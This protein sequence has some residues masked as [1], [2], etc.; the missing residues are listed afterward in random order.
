MSKTEE[1]IISRDC[2]A[3]AVPSGEMVTLPKGSKVNITHRLGGNFTVI[4]DYGMAR[5]DRE[6]VDALGEE[7]PTSVVQNSLKIEHQGP[8]DESAIWE[9]LKTVFD[10]E[11]PVNIVDLGLVYS[12]NI[13]EKENDN[14]NVNV[15]MTLTAP[16][17]GMGP[18]S[19]EDA[20]NKMRDVPGV[21]EVDVE[22]VWDPPWNQD[23]IS[24]EGK[25]QL[26]LI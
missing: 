17:C 13:E 6:N 12:L 4:W 5:I 8:P 19:A 11:I 2:Q 18:V 20:K 22:L 15:T 10:P 3:T 25:M 21:T 24:E 1:R 23:M 26:G 14:Y 9:E 7:L 16:G